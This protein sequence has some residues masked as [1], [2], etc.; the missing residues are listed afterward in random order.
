MQNSLHSSDSRCKESNIHSD[1]EDV[2]EDEM[3][4]CH[5]K[6]LYSILEGCNIL[7]D[8]IFASTQSSRLVSSASINSRGKKSHRS[9]DITGSGD[10]EENCGLEE[11]KIATVKRK[12]RELMKRATSLRRTRAIEQ[13]LSNSRC[14]RY[15]EWYL[16]INHYR[17]LVIQIVSKCP[18][19]KQAIEKRQ[20]AKFR[21]SR[22][23]NPR[24]NSF[25]PQK[26]MVNI[27]NSIKKMSMIHK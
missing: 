21:E 1:D 26:I 12:K 9:S 22:A 6:N 20:N 14:G 15:K 27:K 16:K 5:S 13:L 8:S 17:A 19:I 3:E 11:V 24:N 23:T 18:E 7:E 10:D 4:R 2:D 25:S